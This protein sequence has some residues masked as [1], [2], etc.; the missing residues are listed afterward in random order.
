[1]AIASVSS[2]LSGRKKLH[3]S[4]SSAEITGQHFTFEIVTSTD[5]RDRSYFCR[6]DSAQA[7]DDW[8]ESIETSR[9]EHM[10]GSLNRGTV[11]SRCQVLRLHPSQPSRPFIS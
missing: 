2:L 1:M 6:V 5:G 4:F 11:L 9:S 3:Q 7:S 10:L 8:V